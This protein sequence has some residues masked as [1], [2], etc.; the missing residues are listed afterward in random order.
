MIYRVPR[1]REPT[2]AVATR[3]DIKVGDEA[4]RERDGSSGVG[5]K[6]DI[7]TTDRTQSCAKKHMLVRCQSG[8]LY[9]SATEPISGFGQF[10][11]IYLYYFLVR[12]VKL[13]RR[14]KP[15]RPPTCYLLIVD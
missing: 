9:S 8:K 6:G 7:A 2:K 14:D 12:A 3:L 15:V 1:A 13:L 4:M 11:Y 5:Q 10:C